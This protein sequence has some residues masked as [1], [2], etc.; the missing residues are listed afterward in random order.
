MLDD[1]SNEEV[2]LS[3]NTDIGEYEDRVL[4]LQDRRLYLTFE[5][6]DADSEGLYKSRTTQIVDD[7]LAINRDDER[8][9]IKL[10]DRKPIRLYINSPG[11]CVTEGFA[12]ISV[13][14]LS[15]TP[16]YTINIGSWSSMAFLIGITGHKRF[17]LPHMMFLMHDGST[18]AY[19]SANKAKD[20]M[21]FYQ[22][23]E[24]TVV[25]SHVLKHSHMTSKE[26]DG[27]TRVEY[28]MLPEDAL[29]SGFI[30][31]IVTNIN[32]IL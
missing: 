19:D 30:D 29:S 1:I 5:I 26:Y 3:I 27:L 32:T 24:Q 17:S 20:K 12:L 9:K 4:S 15:K 2:K 6:A 16:V 25:K 7:I 8:K 18:F 23:F 21:D 22:R 11:G 13:I 28:Y 31:E 14:E 10:K